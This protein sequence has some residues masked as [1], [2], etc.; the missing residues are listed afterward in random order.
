MFNTQTHTQIY[1]KKGKLPFLIFVLIVN[2][3]GNKW[4]CKIKSV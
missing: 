3:L 2:F 4:T 1:I